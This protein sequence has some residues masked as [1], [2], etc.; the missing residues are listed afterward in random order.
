MF[1]LNLLQAA[2]VCLSAPVKNNRVFQ[3]S[4]SVVFATER[5]QLYIYLYIFIFPWSFF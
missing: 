4:I 1:I 2:S 5:F 3:I